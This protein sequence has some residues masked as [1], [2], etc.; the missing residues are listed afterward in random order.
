MDIMLQADSGNL[1]VRHRVQ[2]RAQH[3]GSDAPLGSVHSNPLP[4]DLV[5]LYGTPLL[6]ISNTKEI[7][8]FMTQ[9]RWISKKEMDTHLKEI[10]ASCAALRERKLR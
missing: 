4:A 5:L 6:D 8:G 9:K 10:R 7:A 2:A 3:K 1:A